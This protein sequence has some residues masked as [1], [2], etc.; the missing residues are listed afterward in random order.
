MAFCFITA[1][2]FTRETA[3]GSFD[4]NALELI[5]CAIIDDNVFAA[6]V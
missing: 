1:R 2:E 4:L 5:T 3:A 6:C